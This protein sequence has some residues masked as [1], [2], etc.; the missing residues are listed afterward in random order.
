M[1]MFADAKLD[2]WVTGPSSL[3]AT[4]EPSSTG[5]YEVTVWPPFTSALAGRYEINVKLEGAHVQGSPL[6]VLLKEPVAAAPQFS[7]A[8][9]LLV[10]VPASAMGA[11]GVVEIA[12]PIQGAPPS[13]Q[14]QSKNDNG[15]P[16]QT[17]KRGFI[18]E[19]KNEGE[20]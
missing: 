10:S 9:S 20:R 3:S 7:A 11:N 5:V 17:G 12:L 15:A 4:A 16:M 14:V 2:V 1:F 19:N 18:E 13:L 6:V 8:R